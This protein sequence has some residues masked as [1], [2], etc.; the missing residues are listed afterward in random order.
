MA[1][2]LRYPQLQ[3]SR[4]SIKRAYFAVTVAAGRADM[5]RTAKPTSICTSDPTAERMLVVAAKNGDEQAF[6]DLFKRYQQRIFVLAFRF[7]RVR[8]D[9]DDVV[10]ETFQ[11]AFIHFHKFE[12]KSSFST[13]VTRIAIN[14]ALMLLRRRRALSEVPIEDSSN[15][16]ET[17]Q[18]LELVDASPDP[19]ATCLQQ[20]EARILS[21]AIEQLRPGIQ[22]TI[23]LRHLRELSAQ[24][25]ARQLGLSVAAVKARMFHARRKL[26][27]TLRR[28]MRLHRICASDILAISSNAYRSRQDRMTCNA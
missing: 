4:D 14:Q 11:K 6:E 7:T 17:S 13:W 15:H 27:K 3:S 26:A 20:E 25:T 22:R 24:E 19:E 23:Q 28:Q 8:E 10:Q 1:S 9:A 21:A 18:G 2:G 16:D 5:N 12:G